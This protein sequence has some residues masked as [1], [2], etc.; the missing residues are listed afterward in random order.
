VIRPFLDT[1]L[2]RAESWLGNRASRPV[3]GGNHLELLSK[4]RYDHGMI[5]ETI[6]QLRELTPEEKLILSDE[7]W[8]EVTCEEP[9]VPDPEL[10]D[11]LNQGRIVKQ[12]DCGTPHLV[13]DGRVQRLDLKPL[14]QIKNQ[15]P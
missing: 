12:V 13:S 4:S 5:S 6:P 10:V 15:K 8:R 1:S 14:S 2:R 9:G 11:K 7:L 3:P